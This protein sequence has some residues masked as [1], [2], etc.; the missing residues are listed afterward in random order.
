[1]AEVLVLNASYEPLRLVSTRRAVVLL[2]QQK[3]EVVEPGERVIRSN[4]G[5]FAVPEVVRLLRY[6][7]VPRNRALPCSR[8]AVLIRDSETC[9]YCGTKPGRA[10]LTLDHVLPR[11]QGGTTSWENVVAACNSCN[12]RKANR[13]PEQ[14][15]MQLMRQPRRPLYMTLTLIN[16][17][18]RN[19][20]WSKYAYQA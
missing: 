19:D 1:M 2:L 12:H 14:A 11:A 17:L 13:T 4:S 15:N 10:L 16:A 9:Q 6:A 5:R 18:E 8:R 20:V 7:A 3:V